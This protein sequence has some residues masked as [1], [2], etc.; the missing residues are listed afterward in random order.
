MS[1]PINSC[2][3]CRQTFQQQIILTSQK[4]GSRKLINPIGRIS[5]RV[6]R[7]SW[8]AMTRIYLGTAEPFRDI[9]E[10]NENT[11]RISEQREKVGGKEMHNVEEGGMKLAKVRATPRGL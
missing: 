1:Y 7:A 3:R 4:C 11:G 9:V 8:K 2:H 5:E 6:L 10:K